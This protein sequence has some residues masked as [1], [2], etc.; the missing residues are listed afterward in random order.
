DLFLLDSSKFLFDLHPSEF[1]LIGEKWINPDSTLI[2]VQ[3]QEVNFKNVMF[4]NGHDFVEIKGDL[5]KDKNKVLDV[6]ITDL[7]LVIFKNILGFN[8]EGNINGTARLQDVYDSLEMSINLKVDSI[9]VDNFEIGDLSLQASWL[10]V[11]ELLTINSTLTQN[12]K[13]LMLIYGTIHP[14]FA[15]NQLNLH[16]QLYKAD[17]TMIEPFVKDNLSEIDG[18]LTG[19]LRITGNPSSPIIKGNLD[20]QNGKI[21]VNYLN[22]VYR[23]DD[24][25]FFE[26]DHIGVKNFKF[27]DAQGDLAIINGGI[28]HDG[29]E[30][31]LIQVEGTY[32]KFQ[33]LNTEPD[34]N[35]LYYGTANITGD[36]KVFG[37]PKSIDIS[38]NVIT[39]KNTKL[40]LPLDGYADVQKE[41]SFIRFKEK[42]K[43]KKTTTKKKKKKKITTTTTTDSVK[44]IQTDKVIKKEKQSENDTETEIVAEKTT[45]S[46]MKM[47]MN[48]NVDI[49]PDAAVEIIFNKKAGDIMKA[50]GKGKLRVEMDTEGEFKMFGDLDIVKGAYNFTFLNIVNKE[51][52]VGP[53]SRI[54]WTGDPF[55]GTTDIKALYMQRASLAPI[56]DIQDTTIKQRPEIRRRYPVKL[57][58]FVKGKIL[59]PEVKFGIDILDYPTVI[60]AG[61]VAI[62]LDT[63]VNSFKAK[64]DSDEQ[65][66][67][68]QV[69]SLMVLKQ[70]S[71]QNAFSGLGQSAGRSVSELLTNQL[72]NWMSQVDDKLEVQ[73]DLNGLDAD[74]LRTMELRLSYSF[75]GGRM[76]ITRDGG[77][78]NV[79]NKTSAS[80]V[81]GDWTVEY[82]VTLDGKVRLKMYHRNT[83]NTLNPTLS[84]T[85]VQGV[86]VLYTRSFNTLKEL[87][88]FFY[89]EKKPLEIEKE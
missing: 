74:A 67:A 63:Y 66:L 31:I 69:F 62:P 10:N 21:K 30:N 86:S 56:I 57:S 19:K 79:Q 1:H 38:A 23:F 13:E 46:G 3:G 89:E 9:E 68:K 49:T 71:A 52:I 16:A 78:T 8:F 36:F 25:I 24:R 59:S 48:F 28:Y 87:F 26:N 7:E 51:F 53:D 54:S 80:S 32:K 34:P 2:T 84:N 83:A 75:M 39:E 43:V 14:S 41:N 27:R 64:L 81:I 4:S 50:N 33:V 47:K 88:S 70:F 12:K 11:R 58:L 18:F 85:S 61:S 6:K 37:S 44:N 45:E 73:F 60:N 55:G 20:V 29:V 35:T 82:L 72:S 15:Q 65:E 42:P 17:M 77:F 40:S 22:T 76:R 5:S